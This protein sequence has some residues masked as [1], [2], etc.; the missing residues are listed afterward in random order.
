M[1]KEF[2]EIFSGL[3]AGTL[4]LP[5]R[6]QADDIRC[7]VLASG[8]PNAFTAGIDREYSCCLVMILPAH[9]P[10]LYHP[11]EMLASLAPSSSDPS[12]AGIILHDKILALQRT[13]T[14]LTSS[15]L[16]IPV[17][18]AIHGHCIGL[19]VDIVSACDVRLCAE[20]TMFCIKV[21]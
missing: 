7:V 10:L 11:D 6:E 20:G 8:L 21:S 12:R 2:E 16:R 4:E 9:T 5:S 13:L 17:V 14:A 19:G 18:A 1:F 15:H 3:A